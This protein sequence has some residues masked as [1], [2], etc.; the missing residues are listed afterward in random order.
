MYEISLADA[1]FTRGQQRVLG[2]LFSD[3]ARSFLVTE[4]IARTGGGTGAVHRELARLTESG[5]VT[6]NPVGRQRRY[7][8]NRES[9]IFSELRAL[10]LK[11]VGLVEPL[12][13]ALAPLRTRIQAAFVYGLEATEP[14]VKLMVIADEVSS[15]ELFTALDE[16]EKAIGR[17]IDPVFFNPGEWRGQIADEGF[18]KRVATL[19]KIFVIGTEGSLT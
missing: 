16:A 13:G 18:A 11:T 1:L 7:Q 10:I 17:S 6:M 2:T 5:I 12:Q 9:P 14:E 3:P 4:L 8:A 19:P 15:T